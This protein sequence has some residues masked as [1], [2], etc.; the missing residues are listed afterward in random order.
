MTEAKTFARTSLPLSGCVDFE[1]QAW[2]ARR[3][4]PPLHQ[5]SPWPSAMPT[6][7][8]PA[9]PV[10]ASSQRVTMALERP[11]LPFRLPV[12]LPLPGPLPARAAEPPVLDWLGCLAASPSPARDGIA[13]WLASY[14]PPEGLYDCG[15]RIR[16]RCGAMYSV[17]CAVSACG[18]VQVRVPPRAVRR[19][20]CGDGDA[21]TDGWAPTQHSPNPSCVAVTSVTDWQRSVHLFLNVP[22]SAGSTPHTPFDTSA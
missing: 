21:R 16:E 11:S 13:R 19:Q 17:R 22:G 15:A 3:P 12:P 6:S 8:G 20:P 7:H 5:S 4:C 1:P 9:P 18:G 14:L 2:V 10:R